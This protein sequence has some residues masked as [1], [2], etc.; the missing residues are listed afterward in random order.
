MT[1]PS[2]IVA[3][4]NPGKAREIERA[5]PHVR[6][7]TLADHPDLVLP[8][9]TGATF[10][11][12]AR[13]KATFVADALE[14]SAVLADDSGLEVDALGGEPGV[15]SARWA[16]GCDA[17]R[18]RALLERLRGVPAE[19]RTARFVCSMTFCGFGSPVGVEGACTG[20]IANEPRGD[21][22][23][24]YDPVF[25]LNDG[26]TMAE[27]SPEEKNAISHRGQALRKIIPLLEAH[28]AMARGA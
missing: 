2:L 21:G 7:Q 18:V 27:L 4:G 25:V 14:A 1:E 22:G 15:R 5:L 3:T 17:D 9:E 13:M 28:F 8:E 20:R 12:N 11:E 23:F 6:V 16:P 19:H 10:A 24:G 26:R